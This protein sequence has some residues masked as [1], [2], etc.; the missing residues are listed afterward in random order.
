M[1]SRYTV[2]IIPAEWRWVIFVASG[3]V[4]VA[5]LPFLW[6]A[7]SN[8]AQSNWQF[9]GMIGVNY[10]DG[11]TYLAKML[12]GMEGSWLIRF[13]HTP[14]PHNPFFLVPI[15]PLLGQ[16][17][18]FTGL[19]PIVMYH[20][21]RVIASLFMYL[22]IY[23]LGATIWTRVRTRRI[24]FVISAVGAGFGWLLLLVTQDTNAFI[25]DIAIPEAFPLFGT[26]VNVHFPLTMACLALLGSIFINAFRPGMD[27]NPS[28]TN[29]GLLAVVVTMI[30]GVLYPQTLAPL[31]G[32]LVLLTAI[33]SIREKRINRHIFY[34]SL[35][36][37]LPAVPFALYY[38]AVTQSNPVVAE[39]NRQNVTLSPNP[40]VLVV[41]LG[42]PLILALPGIYRALRRF[43]ADGDQFMLLW[44][45]MVITA[46]YFPSSIQRRFMAGIMLLIAYF[47]T[48]A[49]ED[50]W[51]NYVSRRWRKQLFVLFV[52]IIAFSQIFIL[53]VPVLPILAGNFQA[54]AGM[55]LERDYRPTFDWLRENANTGDVILASP[56]VSLWVPA[57]TGLQVV[58]GHPF[59]TLQA[60]EKRQAIEAW[61]TT[62][63]IED[64]QRVLDGAQA[65]MGTYRVRYVLVGP[66]ERLMGSDPTTV[67]SECLNSLQVVGQ[68]GDVT[69]YAP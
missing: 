15:Y 52:P 50:F 63:S 12:Q 59:E 22:A 55:M 14:E 47:A 60:E 36:I 62:S 2:Y 26:Y 51:F 28:L 8:T 19:P 57:W 13:L 24:F 67:E 34:W 44:L 56:N 6:V 9:M 37:I 11:A 7:L 5:F 40:F 4:L 41:G 27:E 20:I 69:I 33:R 17:S 39:W 38:I 21:A 29:G 10:R 49:L 35:V 58:Y 23:Q 18:R 25:P 48:R 65:M 46:V 32:A 30:L 53:I 43:E 54:V 3:L 16:A 31:G 45:V 42:L 1:Q 61:F 68:I 64:C 66:E